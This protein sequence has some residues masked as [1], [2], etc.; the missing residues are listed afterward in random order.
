MFVLIKLHCV[1]MRDGF[2]HFSDMGK[3]V[4][5]ALEHLSLLWVLPYY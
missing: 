5:I 4:P 3:V 2:H 1:R